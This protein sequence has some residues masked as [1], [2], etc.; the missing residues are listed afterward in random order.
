M[1]QF[2]PDED[3]GHGDV[4]TARGRLVRPGGRAPDYLNSCELS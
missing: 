1:V 4:S 3:I 2:L